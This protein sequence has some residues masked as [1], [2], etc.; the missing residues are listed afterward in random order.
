[1]TKLIQ[2]NKVTVM[3]VNSNIQYFEAN[4]IPQ[5]KLQHF[6]YNLNSLLQ[7]MVDF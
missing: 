1:M 7:N 4:I 3:S 5:F 2:Y 6:L